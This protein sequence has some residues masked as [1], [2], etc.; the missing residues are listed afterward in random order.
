MKKL[1][2]LAI[3]L[4]LLTGCG[5]NQIQQ[6]D[7]AVKASWGEVTNQ[8]KRRSDLVPQLVATVKGYAN[9]EEQVLKEV[10]E[11]RSRVGGINLTPDKVPT[12][13]DM[14]Q[15]IQAQGQLTSALNRLN[16]VVEN[17]PNLKANES[18]LNLQTQLEGTEN[19]ITLARNRYIQSVQVYNT[20]IRQFPT[21]ITA[22]IFGY[23]VLPS[24]TV[25]NENVISE[26][27]KV[28]F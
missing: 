20:N 17:Y 28:E 9:H 8:Y 11:A 2:A 5:Y 19:R 18:F 1:W 26:P 27:P 7:E 13:S 22:K 14:Q 25:P 10:T 12:E 23:K 4:F 15:Y 21:L 24:F 3:A 16:V 6:Q